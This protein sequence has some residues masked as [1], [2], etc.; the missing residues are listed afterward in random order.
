MAYLYRLLLACPHILQNF[1]R[2]YMEER[3]KQ[4]NLLFNSKNRQT[5]HSAFEHPCVC[6]SKEAEV[7]QGRIFKNSPHEDAVWLAA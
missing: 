4:C 3:K 7:S 5:S 2:W 6:G 1:L